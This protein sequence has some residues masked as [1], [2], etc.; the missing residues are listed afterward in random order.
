MRNLLEQIQAALEANLYYV[1]L[2]VTLTVP[3]I[4][5]AIGSDTGV[6]RHWKYVQWFDKY[7]AARYSSGSGQVIT[8]E[9][10]Y[11]FRCS[12]LH[13]GTSQSPKSRYGRVFFVEPRDSRATMHCNVHNDALNI[14]LRIF[15]EDIIAGA[16]Q[17]LDEVEGTPT[18]E[19]NYNKFM[20]RYP[21]GL[22]PFV[23]GFPVIG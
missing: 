5:G 23:V 22:A 20:R 1:G 11:A 17:W 18:F 7:L 2:M 21:N 14:D 16:M 4:C 10:C 9:D 3:D 6:A 15:C 8:G 12:L 19:R 13:Q